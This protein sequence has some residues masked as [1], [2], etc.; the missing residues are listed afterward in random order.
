M[1]RIGIVTIFDCDNYGADLQAY[2]LPTALKQLGYHAELIDYP[3]YK[4]ARFRMTK[5]ARP[6]VPLS[7]K[8]RLKEALARMLAAWRRRFGG[9]TVRRRERAFAAFRER[10]PLSKTTYA[11][12]NALTQHPPAYDIYMTGSDQVWNPR[13]GATLRPYFLDFLPKE[14]VRIAYAASFGVAELPDSVTEHYREWMARYRAVGCREAKG[15]DLV[16]ALCPQVPC[17]HTLDPTLLLTREAWASVANMPERAAGKRYLLIYEL[18]PAKGLAD[19]ARRW[20][21]QEGLDI[22]RICGSAKASA[23]PG[24]TVLRE[25]G[26]DGFVGLFSEASAVVTTSFHG[27]VFSLIFGV[28]FYSVIPGQM[29]NSSRQRGLLETVGCPDRL[30]PEHQLKAHIPDTH[31]DW[32]AIQERLQAARNASLDF[33]RTAV[34]GTPH[35]S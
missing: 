18:V 14:A 24:E 31:L 20:A 30:L 1:T 16:R 33:L 8:N 29:H 6:V 35:A 11:T 15:C 9:A 34:E 22:I 27:T 28:P 25:L 3:F 2:A 17:A 32:E 4:S 10:M 19:F 5:T 7:A 13:M 26:P 21:H 12:F 23:A